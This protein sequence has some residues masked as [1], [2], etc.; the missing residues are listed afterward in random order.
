M[1]YFEWMSIK[2][3]FM[4]SR[5]LFAMILAVILT[6]AAASCS[7]EGGD[8]EV[9]TGLAARIGD[10]KITKAEVD[11]RFEQLSEKQKDDFK[12][13][14]GKAEFLDKLIEEEIIYKEAM[15]LKLQYDPEIKKVLRQAERN[16]LVS[17]YFNREILE[18]IDVAEE[19][20]EAYYEGNLLEFTTRAVIKA[21]HTF[22]TS[23]KK[24]EEWKRR[25][26]GGEDISKIAKEESEDELTSTHAGNLGYFNP[27]GYIKFI[28]RS[29][30]WSD[31]VNELEAQET[32]DIIEFEKGF[33]IVR[34][35]EKN[36]ERILPLS[37]V[38]QRIIEKLRAQGA[39][40]AYEIA[41]ARLKDSHK[42]SN[43]LREELMASTRTPEQ[44]WEIAQMESDPYERIQYYRQ[45]VELY[46]DHDYAPQALFMIGFVYAEELQ[47]KV[48]AR[49]RLDE[50]L[51]KYPDSEVAASAKWMIDNMNTPHP[52]FESFENMKEAME[53]E[54]SE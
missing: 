6:V 23:R 16:I 15:N 48:E 33:S 31:A 19:E 21:Q 38:R 40:S 50:L 54:D 1:I 7:N 47:N 32:S 35:Q 14:R 22:T 44:Y 53:G 51:Q 43:F 4:D 42:P 17:E 49:R 10:S 25:L 45:I 3:G 26:A 5:R 37:D 13:K 39:R 18:K 29:P 11:E 27:G 28:G 8:V 12:G 34:V 2:G 41:I 20:V 30:T 46:P 9:N 24:A 52:S 36:P